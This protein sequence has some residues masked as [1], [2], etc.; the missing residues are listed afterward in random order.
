MENSFAPRFGR[1]EKT[2]NTQIVFQHRAL[3]VNRVHQNCSVSM[4][5]IQTAIFESARK[6]DFVRARFDE[7]AAKKIRHKIGSR[8]DASEVLNRLRRSEYFSLL[9]APA[10]LERRCRQD[11]PTKKRN[12]GFSKGST[13]SKT[14]G[15][16]SVEAIHEDRIDRKFGD[17][18]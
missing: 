4:N 18:K 14:Q 5:R 13:A 1:S 3:I 15:C 10:F 11:E 6:F 7:S 16:K 2:R 9:D 17:G 12:A 8:Q